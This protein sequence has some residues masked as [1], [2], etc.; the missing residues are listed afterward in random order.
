MLKVEYMYIYYTDKCTSFYAKICINC[1]Q[2]YRYKFR[3]VVKRIGINS[4]NNLTASFFV[5][6]LSNRHPST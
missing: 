6:Y 1:N 5:L 4:F 2:M 3:G